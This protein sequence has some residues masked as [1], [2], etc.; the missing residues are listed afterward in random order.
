M[1]DTINQIQMNLFRKIE[2]LVILKYKKIVISSLSFSKYEFMK[3]SYFSDTCFP[4]QALMMLTL[5]KFQMH[6]IG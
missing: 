5:K 3:Y 4:L 6:N 2:F 1:Y